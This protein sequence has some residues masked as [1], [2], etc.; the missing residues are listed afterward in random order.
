[1]FKE[2]VLKN[3]KMIGNVDKTNTRNL[4]NWK[5]FHDCW[6]VNFKT[7]IRI[8]LIKKASLFTFI[9]LNNKE[10]KLFHFNL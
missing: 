2:K 8:S 1:M 6:L 10:S 9:P 7:I 4:M 3:Q 5:K